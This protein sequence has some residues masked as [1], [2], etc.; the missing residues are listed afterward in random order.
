MRY[1]TKL[2]YVLGYENVELKEERI[3]G[4]WKRDIGMENVAKLVTQSHACRDDSM[5]SFDIC[6]SSYNN[7]FFLKGI[8]TKIVNILNYIET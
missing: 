1:S 4:Y 7:I 8:A 6:C 2:T 3:D 5:S